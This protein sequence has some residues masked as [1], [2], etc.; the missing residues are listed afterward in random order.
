MPWAVVDGGY[1]V[2]EVDAVAALKLVDADYH[3]G[4]RDGFVELDA[5]VWVL[6][7]RQIGDHCYRLS[8]YSG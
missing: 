3:A 1:Y 4:G 8:Y 6:V 2:V 5:S 7:G